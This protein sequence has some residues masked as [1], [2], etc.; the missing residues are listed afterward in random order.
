MQE[1]VDYRRA[2]RGRPSRGAR[3]RRIL[4]DVPAHRRTLD[5]GLHRC[6]GPLAL[7]GARRGVVQPNDFIPALESSGQI[8]PVGAWVIH[9]AC[10]QGALWQG[11]GHT[12]SV[13][14]NISAKQL[15]RDSSCR[16]CKTPSRSPASIPTDLILELTETALMHDSGSTLERMML[17]K[18]LGVRIAIDDFGTGYSSLAYLR[19]FPI[20][21]LKI[22][23]SFVSGIADSTR[24]DCARAHSRSIRE[25]VGHRDHR[26][27]RRDQS[28]ANPSRNRAC[29]HRS[30]VSLRAPTLGRRPRQVTQRLSGKAGVGSALIDDYGF[31]VPSS[32]VESPR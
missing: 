21:I 27:R 4:P 15:E 1:S 19:Q 8:I 23:R 22:D 28:P 3:E 18:A 11:R 25:G 29:R 13:S 6:G 14:V 12:F 24:I 30:R 2:P 20:D 26:G 32:D 5:R 9:E 10:R 17:L 31:V 7:G 16:T